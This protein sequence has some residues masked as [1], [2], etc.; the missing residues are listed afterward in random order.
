MRL[1]EY[2]IP[3]SVQRHVARGKYMSTLS[4]SGYGNIVLEV[5]DIYEDNCVSLTGLC[6]GQR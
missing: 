5:K 2:T 1:F 6:E 3:F 4:V